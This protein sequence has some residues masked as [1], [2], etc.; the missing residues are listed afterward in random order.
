MRSVATI[1]VQGEA[2]PADSSVRRFD[3]SEKLSAPYA[4]EIEFATAD[5][6]FRAEACLRTR[7]LVTIDGG[8]NRLRHF[9]GLIDEARFVAHTGTLLHFRLRLRPQLATLGHRRGSRIFQDMSTVD[10]VKEVL[11][12]AGVDEKVE[13]RFSKTYGPREFVVQYRETELNFVSRLLEDEGLFYFFE[14]GPDGHKMVV[15]DD[16]SAFAVAPHMSEVR[17]GMVQGL[18]GATDPLAVFRREKRL[19]TTDVQLR[20]FEFESPQL[21]PEAQMSEAGSWPMP[22]YAYPGGFTFGD[23]AVR[24]AEACMH[25]LRA[26]A[27]TVKGKSVAVGLSAGMPFSVEGASESCCNGRFVVTEIQ[28][29]GE[30]SPDETGAEEGDNLACTN[31]FSGIPE[32]APF[33]AERKA[34]KP[35]IHGVQTAI[36]TG[37]TNEQ[38]AIHVDKFGRVKVRFH[39]D[40]AGKGDD[41]S[42]CWLRVVQLGLGGSMILP[43]VGWEL[44]VAFLDG[45]PD[46]PV[47]IG[48]LYNGKQGTLEDLP[49]GAAKSAMKSLSTPGGA[50]SNQLG[51]DDSGGSQGFGLKGPKDV[52]TFVG[53]GRSEDVGVQED[54]K[55]TGNMSSMVG[56]NETVSIGA[57]QDIN[58]GNALQTKCA[59]Q[60]ISVGANE[61]VGTEANYIAAIGGSRTHS[62]AANRI[63]ICNGVRTFVSSSI[64][65]DVGAVQIEAS[66]ATINETHG[67]TYDETVGALKAEIIAGVGA[68]EVA[69]AKSQNMSAG[70]IHLVANFASKAASVTRLVGGA[71]V[72]M[73][74]GNLEVSASTIKL[75]GG[76]GHF[77]GGGSAINLNG[78]PVVLKGSKI[79]IK[80][81]LIRKA[82]GALK[83]D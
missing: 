76:I 71:H 2:L 27:D 49:G 75:L 53:G 78:G 39:W 61:V 38:Q 21:K 44:A 72:R 11:A 28:T 34:G 12:D 52:N 50:G 42:S 48:R 69:G 83:L 46:R 64:T 5:L 82:A 8:E 16:P 47:A 55:V 31:T 14:H 60:S 1:H 43:R 74:G 23:D 77:K 37:P 7:V 66:A 36:V 58:V 30:Q 54:H 6:A 45:D 41:T 22:Y 56:A 26:D 15:A 17:F 79:A 19:R 80:A 51:T 29:T 59:S 24:R 63:T 40:R 70:E 73:A 65:R 9:D 3:A 57:N 32:G 62:I 4:C 68:E 18:S 13:W 33:A 25:G 10:I 35:Q 20:D 81:A 67:S